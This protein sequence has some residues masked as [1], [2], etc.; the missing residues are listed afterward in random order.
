MKTKRAKL[1]FRERLCSVGLETDVNERLRVHSDHFILAAQPFI[2]SIF[3][4]HVRLSLAIIERLSSH[5]EKRETEFTVNPSLLIDSVP[6]DRWR[7]P[8][9]PIL[10]IS[11]Y[12]C[13][14]G[15]FDLERAEPASRN[16]IVSTPPSGK[17]CEF[18]LWCSSV[19]LRALEMGI[20]KR[21][22]IS[23]SASVRF[24]GRFV[25]RS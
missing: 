20:S 4:A 12:R 3:Q 16:A 14:V 17:E 22:L 7:R 8:F 25:T 23:Y 19:C 13:V 10:L 24:A 1:S 9:P 21:K 11:Q 5:R 15:F 2:C 6:E 18:H